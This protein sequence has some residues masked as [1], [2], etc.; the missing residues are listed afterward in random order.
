MAICFR[1]P[2]PS[3]LTANH[4]T[5]SKRIEHPEEEG[6]FNKPK[7]KKEHFILAEEAIVT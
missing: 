3:Q 2:L 5:S 7:T 4:P 1:S 6:H